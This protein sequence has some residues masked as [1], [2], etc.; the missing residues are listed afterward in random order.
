M[1]CSLQGITATCS[2][3]DSKSASRSSLLFLASSLSE[4]S[5]YFPAAS[6]LDSF[7]LSS[8]KNKLRK[9][10]SPFVE[11][12]PLFLFPAIQLQGERKCYYLFREIK[13][14]VRTEYTHG[15]NCRF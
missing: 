15:N 8:L 11:I 6:L 3:A 13:D 7:F 10:I 9:A 5:L 14:T 1:P 2:K 12:F 4:R